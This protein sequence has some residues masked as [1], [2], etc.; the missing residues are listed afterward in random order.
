MNDFD[1]FKF[2]RLLLMIA[3]GTYC[4]ITMSTRIWNNVRF[5]RSLPYSGLLWKYLLVQLLRIRLKEFLRPLVE[6][7]LLILTLIALYWAHNQVM[8]HGE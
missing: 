7:G 4:V 3:V 1:L 6:I 2:Y 8:I 5:G